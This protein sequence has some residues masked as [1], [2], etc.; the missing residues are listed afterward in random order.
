MLQWGKLMSLSLLICQ[1]A[2]APGNGKKSWYDDHFSSWLSTSLT[3]EKTNRIIALL[4]SD[5]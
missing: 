5:Q 2:F 4:R 3:D 1:Q